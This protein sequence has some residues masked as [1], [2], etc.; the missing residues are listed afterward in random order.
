MGVYH[1]NLNIYLF[2]V[3]FSMQSHCIPP[4]L[5]IKWIPPLLSEL[6]QAKKQTEGK[7]TNVETSQK[8]AF[9]RCSWLFSR[10][11][12]KAKIF[13]PSYFTSVAWQTLQG[14]APNSEVKHFPFRPSNRT[15]WCGGWQKTRNT[16]SGA[17]RRYRHW[18]NTVVFLAASLDFTMF[19]WLIR[20][21]TT[22]SKATSS[23][24]LWR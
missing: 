21:R 22:F 20:R 9:E 24:R 17:G 15:S 11:V 7:R 6:S 8:G 1:Y 16:A 12:M 19:T 14:R 4:N 23:P 13:N 5:F 2:N 18:R 10:P 3:F